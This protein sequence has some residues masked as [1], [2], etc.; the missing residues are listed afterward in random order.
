MKTEFKDVAHL[1][2]GCEIMTP[3][4]R[5]FLSAVS[6]SRVRERGN[7]NRIS[8]HFHEILHTKSSVD[9]YDKKRNYGDYLLTAERYTA[10]ATSDPDF[11]EF[12]MPGGCQPILRPL[13]DMT[14]E[15]MNACAPLILADPYKLIKEWNG[16]DVMQFSAKCALYL[17]KQ[18]FDLFDLIPSGQAIDAT[19]LKAKA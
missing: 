11:T 8:V 1:Y 15:E 2:L 3:D 12:E 14:E 16:T 10:I 18:G 9:G 17:L 5:G 19:T 13:S 7:E 6:F 4:G